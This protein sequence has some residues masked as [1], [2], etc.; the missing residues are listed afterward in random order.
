MSTAIDRARDLL[1]DTNTD[2]QSD[3]PP[4]FIDLLCVAIELAKSAAEDDRHIPVE[5]T[6]CAGCK[7]L[8]QFE[9]LFPEE[10]A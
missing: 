8:A 6:D 9:K 1:A 3:L 4:L 5:A 10:K 7:A 2:K